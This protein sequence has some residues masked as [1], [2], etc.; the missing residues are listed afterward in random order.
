LFVV[1]S[2]NFAINSPSQCVQ[3]IGLL[4]EAENAIVDVLI[5]ESV[6]DNGVETNVGFGFLVVPVV[7]IKTE[8]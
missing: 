1:I 8:T 3:S 6:V 5:V 4:K 7:C 2:S